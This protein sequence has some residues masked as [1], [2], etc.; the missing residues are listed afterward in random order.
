[1]CRG[2]E[3]LFTA[4][5]KYCPSIRCL[6]SNT[7]RVTE[8][9]P[10][11]RAYTRLQTRF[12]LSCC[13]SERRSVR[14]E[15]DELARRIAEE[16]SVLGKTLVDAEA[17]RDLA[18]DSVRRLDP[19]V[20]AAINSERGKLLLLTMPSASWAM[21]ATV[22]ALGLCVHAQECLR[23]NRV[24]CPRQMRSRQD[25]F[26]QLAHVGRN[27]QHMLRGW[28]HMGKKST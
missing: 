12:I 7:E 15:R 2:N 26:M 5:D 16:A 17:A 6:F 14:Q 23:Q 22:H 25:G 18:G 9:V 8:K 13:S 24:S 21:S 10:P 3:A 4:L 28:P 1:M 19:I 11:S 20:A 27:R